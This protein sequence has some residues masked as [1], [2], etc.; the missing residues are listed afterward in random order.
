MSFAQSFRAQF[1][2]PEGFWGMVAGMIMA[3]RGSNIE[4]NYWTIDLLG[5]EPE[6]RVLEI[7]FGPGIAME[8]AA[9]LARDGAV[10]GVD[11]SQTMLDQ[12]VKR[13]ASAIAEGRVH[14]NLGSVLSLPESSNTFDRIY[15]VNSLQFWP[16]PVERLREL[17]KLLNA[18][19]V[20]AITHQPRQAGATDQDT[21]ESGKRI[22]EMLTAAGFRGVKIKWKAMK[23]V[24]VVCVL[25]EGGGAT[26][27]VARV[28]E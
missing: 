19:G 23:P 2:K 17:H 4:R 16:E 7:G 3:S 14:L 12:A 28:E 25:A 5:I 21:E 26:L 6:H 20:I 24:A 9:L 8:R 18:D 13:N 10:Y 15:A 27:V 22:A 1:G 11:H